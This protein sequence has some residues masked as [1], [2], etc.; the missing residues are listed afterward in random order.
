M[1]SITNSID[2]YFNKN[3]YSE[4][5]YRLILNMIEIDEKKRYSFKEIDKELKHW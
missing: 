3:L 1:K 5:L 2:K 4:K